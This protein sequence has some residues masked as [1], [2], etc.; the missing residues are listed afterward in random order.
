VKEFEPLIGEWQ[1]EGEMPMDPPVKISA[2]A[3]IERLG[4]FVVF[5]TVGEPADAAFHRRDLR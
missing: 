5:S 2:E 4:T 3:K 1:G